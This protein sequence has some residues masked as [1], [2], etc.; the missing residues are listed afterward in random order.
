[1]LGTSAKAA[2]L[3]VVLNP[4]PDIVSGFI[5]VSYNAGSQ[6]F[7]AAGYAMSIND[8]GSPPN[9]DIDDGLFNITASVN[10]AGVAS[11]GSI[12]ING[13]F[14]AF[15]P[16]LLTGNL[17][18]M[19]FQTGGGS[20]FD[21]LFTVTGGTLATPAYYGL[22]GSVF[23]VILNSGPN[24]FNGSWANSWNNGAP[25]TGVGVADTAPIP[26]PGAFGLLLAAASFGAP[27]RRRA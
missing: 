16:S 11:G 26:A 2:L 18:A 14:G 6:T 22:P 17:L 1:M 27:R 12:V 21:F 7:V 8:D 15:G 10:N 9:P 5:D 19:G 25:G 3:G 13:T 24:N 4:Y 23:G 20:V